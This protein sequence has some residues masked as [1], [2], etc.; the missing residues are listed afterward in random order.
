LRERGEREKEKDSWRLL[1]ERGEK[2]KEKDSWRLLRERGGI[3]IK[4]TM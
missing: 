1:R 3:S 2:E 4:L